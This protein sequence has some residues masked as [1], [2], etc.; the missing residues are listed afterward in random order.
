MK[1]GIKGKTALD[2]IWLL[3][4]RVYGGV[5]GMGLFRLFGSKWFSNIISSGLHSISMT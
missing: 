3:K 5:T 4:W 2:P 1:V